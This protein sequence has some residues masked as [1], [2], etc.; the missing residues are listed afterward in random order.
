M[1][2]RSG[3]KPGTSSPP[4]KNPSPKNAMRKTPTLIGNVSVLMGERLRTR[5]NTGAG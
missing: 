2:E 5:R 3:K 4:E 1:G